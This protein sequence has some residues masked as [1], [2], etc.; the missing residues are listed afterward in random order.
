MDYP[1][2][3][4]EIARCGISKQA[5]AAQMGLSEQAFYNKLAG[6]T[7]FKNSE[8]KAIAKE[9]SLSME[10]VNFIFFDNGVN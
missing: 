5:L 10:K 1:G 8:I 9:L 4:A 3:R 7:E 2:L 6:R